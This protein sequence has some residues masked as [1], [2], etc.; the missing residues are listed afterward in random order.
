MAII[1]LAAWHAAVHAVDFVAVTSDV[2]MG[3]VL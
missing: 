2:T 1:T 3:E